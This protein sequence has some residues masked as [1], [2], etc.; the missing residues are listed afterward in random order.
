MKR[1]ILKYGLIGVTLLTGCNNQDKILPQRKDIVDVVFAS[2]TIVTDNHY[3]ATSQSEG[4]LVKS[5]VDE[6]DTVCTGQVLFHISDDAQKSQLE[7]AA[8]SY[9]YALNNLNQNSAVLEQ[10][11]AQRIQTKNKLATDSLN[12]WRYK[13]LIKSKAVS[14]MEYEKAKLAFENS[15]QE[16]LSVENRIKDT[17]KSLELELIKAKANLTI[18]QN[19]SSYYTLISSADGIL[20]QI[21]KTD[22][23]LIK[24]GETIAEIGSGDFIAKLFVSEGDINKIVVGQEVYIELNTE[25][26]K[27]YQAKLTKIFPSFDS[28]EQSFIAEARFDEPALHLKSGTQLQANIVIRKKQNALVIPSN[29][30]LPDD[31][32]I[33]SGKREKTKVQ[34][35]IRTVE[36]TEILQGLDE[37]TSIVL[38]D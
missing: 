19:S 36:W 34:V 23:E 18:Q 8:A 28:K 33:K 26:Q 9:G 2:G 24:K 30:L 17:K 27:A 22:G 35:G 20:L 21:F 31:Y 16:L 6:G 32:L 12:F 11:N 5:F 13:N 37:N 1:I 10:L 3:F 7:S 14:Q 38:P 25:K 4:Y 15:E 29:Y